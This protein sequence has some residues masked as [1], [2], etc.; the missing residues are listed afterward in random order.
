M[1]M[2][3]YLSHVDMVLFCYIDVGCSCALKNFDMK[4]IQTLKLMF[5]LWRYSKKYRVYLDHVKTF[6]M[7]PPKGISNH[8][9]K[10]FNFL[11]TKLT[12]KSSK[13]ISPI[14]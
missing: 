3:N 4:T 11:D 9:H 10:N 7:Q 12:S 2:V 14:V 13:S 1:G 8:S 5:S 6:I